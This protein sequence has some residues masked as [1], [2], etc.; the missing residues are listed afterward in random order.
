[1]GRAPIRRRFLSKGFLLT[2]GTYWVETWGCDLDRPV[3]PHRGVHMYPSQSLA[4]V[5]WT[6]SGPNEDLTTQTFQAAVLIKL[7]CKRRK[8]KKQETRTQPSA[9]K[10]CWYSW[11]VTR[12]NLLIETRTFQAS[13]QDR[14][15]YQGQEAE[16][17]LSQHSPQQPGQIQS[18]VLI[19]PTVQPTTLITFLP[20]H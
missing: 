13:G 5:C 6:A 10:H 8:K 17:L 2:L 20:L 12:A 9:F 14:T 4:R 16:L 18:P 15:D 1:M 3:G 7:L 11:P 19:P